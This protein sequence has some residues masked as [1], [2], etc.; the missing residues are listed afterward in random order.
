MRAC[1]SHVVLLMLLI[2]P[3][4]SI[5]ASTLVVCESQVATRDLR[6]KRHSMQTKNGR[7]SS[8]AM[9]LLAF[10]S[11]CSSMSSNGIMMLI[12]N[13]HLHVHSAWLLTCP[14]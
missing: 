4:W 5:T 3:C 14:A 2:M 6:I 13:T 7:L 8:T 12:S 1:L 10:A 9:H 11:N